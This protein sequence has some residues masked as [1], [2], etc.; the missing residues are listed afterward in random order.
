MV[1]HTPIDRERS[2]E[3]IATAISMVLGARP[4]GCILPVLTVKSEEKQ[5][6]RFPPIHSQIGSIQPDGRAPKTMDIAVAQ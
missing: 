5:N 2:Y 4:S 6:S 1:I 3:S